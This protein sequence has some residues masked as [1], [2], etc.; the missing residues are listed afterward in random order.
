LE[1]SLPEVPLVLLSDRDDVEEVAKAIHHGVRG[2]PSSSCRSSS[3]PFTAW[4][5]AA[6]SSRP[7]P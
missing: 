7:I 5:R 1:R 2:Y 3:P 4:K 6:L